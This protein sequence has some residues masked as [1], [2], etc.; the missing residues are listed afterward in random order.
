MSDYRSRVLMAALVPADPAK[1]IELEALSLKDHM[2]RAGFEW[3]NIVRTEYGRSYGFIM[4]V[5]DQGRD[6][7]QPYNARAQYLSGYP[8]SAPIL[9]GA[10]FMSE[11]Q[12]PEDEGMDLTDIKDRAVAYIRDEGKWN[13]EFP[14]FRSW[15]QAYAEHIQFYEGRYP[16]KPSSA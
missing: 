12:N 2:A 9:G 13:H 6:L 7:R 4:M 8:L 14:S 5:D 10:L 1:P 16:L 11:G 15:R 3:F